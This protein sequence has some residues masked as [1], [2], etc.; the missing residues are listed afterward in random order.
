MADLVLSVDVR[1][2]ADARKK[3][4]AFQ[5]EMNGLSVNRLVSGVNSVQNSIKQL[6]DAKAKGTIGFKTY[7]LGLEQL[8]GAYEKMGYSTAKA[9]A[10]VRE[11]RKQLE[12]QAAAKR[13]AQ[14]AEE[15]ARAQAQVAARILDLKRRFKEGYAASEAMQMQ[16]RDLDEALRRGIIT[17]EEY[18]KQLDR[19]K[20]GQT[21]F[22]ASANNLANK[23]S[24]SSVAIQ[25]FG[26][27]TGDFLVQVQSGTNA[28][29]AFGQQATQLAG[30]LTLSLNPKMVILG[31][32][33]SI[34]IPLGTAAAAMFA[35]TRQEAEGAAEGVDDFDSAIK[36]LDSSLREWV[37]TKQAAEL[38]ITP[39]QMLG[40]EALSNAEED[41]RSATEALARLQAAQEAIARMPMSPEG[42]VLALLGFGGKAN[43]T[44]AE[45]DA[46]VA[47]VEAAQE[48]LRIIR[49]K[50]EQERSTQQ[51]K[52]ESF[53]AEQ[54]ALLEDQTSL[55][56]EI[57]KYG[58][59]S[60]QVEEERAR[61]ARIAYQNEL[62][63]QKVGIELIPT[64]MEQYDAMVKAREESEK[65]TRNVEAMSRVGTDSIVAQVNNLAVAL[66]TTAENAARAVGGVRML[67]MLQA[68]GGS[69]RGQG[70]SG[71]MPP[72]PGQFVV[73]PEIEAAYQEYLKSLRG[74]TEEGAGGGV[75]P[76]TQLQ[77]RLKLETEL[78]GKSEAQQRVIQALG[79]NWRSYGEET[80]NSLVASIEEMDRFNERVKQQ[81]QLADSI[82]NSFGDAFMSI[83]DGTKSTKDAFKD[84]A[85]AI[86]ADLYQMF[87]VKQITGFIGNAIM[88]AMGGG[89]PTRP[90]MNP[91][92]ASGGSMMSGRPYLVGEHGPELVIPGRSSTVTNADLTRKSMGGSDG[93]VVNQT[94]NVNGGTD[95]AA[96]RQEVAKLMPAITNATKTAV[97]DARRRGGQ[98]KAAFG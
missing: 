31:A 28:F 78:L 17:L 49:D 69:G 50:E 54:T 26:Y 60:A 10:L 4:S 66:N 2:L 88:G 41:L 21:G 7:K 52:V 39:E 35:R 46:A 36:S 51:D 87:V 84:M 43:A 67:A 73:T 3:L 79:V 86:I 22:A 64:L 45:I 27:Q 56:S 38:G 19:I 98:M 93:V 96:I 97:I 75:D 34:L 16:F 25:Q 24:R 44:Q 72:R 48:R 85:R 12:N 29:V 94:I 68:E 83:V 23:M 59:K 18:R 14:A 80:V 74:G 32:A 71:A 95:P 30:L 92:R 89:G 40:G 1:S 82:A 63:R 6:V 57:A 77:Q 11:Y 65:T 70:P 90:T 76:L 5:K 15:L 20:A 58:E 9:T 55:Y 37:R 47:N 62:M 33:L 91:R 42:A 61:Q 13:A 8:V 53:I 81:Q